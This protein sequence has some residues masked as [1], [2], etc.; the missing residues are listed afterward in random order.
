MKVL[1]RVASSSLSFLSLVLSVSGEVGAGFDELLVVVFE[2]AEGFGVEVEGGAL[3]VEGL[4]TGEEFE[5]EV[6]GVL[7]GG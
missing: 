5:V 2:E 7:M 4:D 6:D 1:E 3:F